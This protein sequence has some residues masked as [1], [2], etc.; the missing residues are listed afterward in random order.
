MSRRPPKSTLTDTLVPY[1]TL[2][3]SFGVKV[4]TRERCEIGPVDQRIVLE[5]DRLLH[6][7]RDHV[8]P[9]RDMA[10]IAADLALAQRP[11]LVAA[12]RGLV[13]DHARRRAGAGVEEAPGERRARRPRGKGREIGRAHV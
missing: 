5:D 11:P 1:T 4:G 10:R 3:R 6:P 12:D 9:D 2:V 8:L 13:D 7:A